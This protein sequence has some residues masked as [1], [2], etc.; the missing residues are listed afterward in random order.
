MICEIMLE[1]YK[2]LVPTKLTD[3]KLLK[4]S[5]EIYMKFDKIYNE[6]YN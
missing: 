1:D 2:R 5:H 6:L 4:D 3:K